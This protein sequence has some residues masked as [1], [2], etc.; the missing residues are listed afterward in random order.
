LKSAATATTGREPWL[1]SRIGRTAFMA[2]ADH[3]GGDQSSIVLTD[4]R[5]AATEKPYRTERPEAMD[6][7]AHVQASVPAS[8]TQLTSVATVSGKSGRAKRNP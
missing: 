6:G 2:T 3:K 1:P 5:G 4:I 8:Q 7:P